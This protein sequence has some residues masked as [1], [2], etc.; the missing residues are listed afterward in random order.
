[1]LGLVR[2]TSA[3]GGPD[4]LCRTQQE[5]FF[6]SWTTIPCTEDRPVNNVPRQKVRFRITD[7]IH[8][9]PARVL[10]ELFRDLRL[11]GEV[12][13]QTN[14]GDTPFLVVRVDGLS[15]TVIV[16]LDKTQPPEPAASD[17]S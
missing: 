3:G 15:E 7:L 1:L 13:D 4:P 17:V 11:E 8:P 2:R 5:R 9:H 14:D 12:A 16:P 6:G 10:L